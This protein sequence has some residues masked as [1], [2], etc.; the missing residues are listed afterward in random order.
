MSCLYF[1][2]WLFWHLS[3]FIIPKTLAF[4]MSIHEK[5]HVLSYDD[6]KKIKQ[7][8]PNHCFSIN[9]YAKIGYIVDAQCF[10]RYVSS[11]IQKIMR[12][13]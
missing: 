5:L 6:K 12:P 4:I 7:Q 13:T 10:T 9:I 1:F 3:H 11:E 8:V 2:N